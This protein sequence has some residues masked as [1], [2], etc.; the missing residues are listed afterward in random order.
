MGVERGGARAKGNPNAEAQHDTRGKAT[1]GAKRRA[2]DDGRGEG[3]GFGESNV[4]APHAHLSYALHGYLLFTSLQLDVF[5]PC[6]IKAEEKRGVWI[7]SLSLRS[8]PP[9][10]GRELLLLSGVR[11]VRFVRFVRLRCVNARY[12]QR[13]CLMSEVSLTSGF[14]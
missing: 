12:A 9:D 5:A 10:I 1:P 13:V 14:W 6:A 7:R 11:F 8:A 4:L 3:A 2:R